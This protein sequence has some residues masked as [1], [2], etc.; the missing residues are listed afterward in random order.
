VQALKTTS[1]YNERDKQVKNIKGLV[2]YYFSYPGSQTVWDNVK[3]TF[4]P[5]QEIVEENISK[6]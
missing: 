3:G 2:A 4:E 6:T 1:K 5:I